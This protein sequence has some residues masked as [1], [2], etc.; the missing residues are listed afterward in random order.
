MSPDESPPPWFAIRVRSN[1]ERTTSKYLASNGYEEFTPFCRTKRRWSDRTREI[2]R[3]LFPGYV[4]CRFLAEDRLPVLKTPGVVSIVSFGNELAQVDEQ[5]I[6][7]LQAVVGNGRNAAPW[8]FLRVGQ[9][10]RVVSGALQGV[11]GLLVCVKNSHRLI[12]SVSLLQRSV[13][14]EVDREDVEPVL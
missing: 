7:N 10:V 5:E 11:E 3:P 2:E 6:A 4:F 1:F 9:R 13:G 12:V 8:P 14:A